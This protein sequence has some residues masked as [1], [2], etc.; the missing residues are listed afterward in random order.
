M[1]DTSEL[2]GL[3]DEDIKLKMV[4]KLSKLWN[5]VQYTNSVD[6]Y[7]QLLGA[8]SIKTLGDFLQECQAT[9]QW[10]GYVSRDAEL[11]STTK[12]LI[13]TNKGTDKEII[14]I[15][16]SVSDGGRIVPYDN[17][18]NALRL[19]VQG[20]RPSGFRSI[21]ILLNA[22]SGINEHCITGYMFTMSNQ[23]PSRTLLVSRN[24]GQ[25]NKNK[26]KGMVIYVNPNSEK[27]RFNIN[28]ES[29]F[30]SAKAVKDS[31]SNGFTIATEAEIPQ[32]IE[33]SGVE[34]SYDEIPERNP[35]KVTKTKKTFTT[36]ETKQTA[37]K[38]TKRSNKIK[39]KITK[40]GK[41]KNVNKKRKTT[42][43]N[44]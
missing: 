43:K 36:Q 9:V 35:K 31:G 11:M 25:E 37:G 19:G 39:S 16:R 20:D 38:K 12:D 7:N 22:S 41:K 26:L 18:G 28:L 13:Q 34:F 1:M 27:N 17:Y 3:S 10:G 4:D 6:N 21:Y 42:H 24:M 8:T 44:I 15:Y 33:T 32:V 5:A 40:K 30:I 29:S 2:I 14:P 23:K